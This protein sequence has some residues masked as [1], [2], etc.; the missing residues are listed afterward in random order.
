MTEETA[1]SSQLNP[2]SSSQSELS[3]D[4]KSAVDDATTECENDLD[5]TEFEVQLQDECTD[6]N[7]PEIKQLRQWALD[8]NIQHNHLDKLLNILRVRLIPNL[9]KSSKTFLKTESTYHLITNI[10]D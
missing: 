6:Q 8:C 9:P 1:G 5:D 7:I 4:N 10:D 2:A 3:L